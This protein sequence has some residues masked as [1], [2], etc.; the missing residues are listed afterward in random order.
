MLKPAKKKWYPKG[1]ALLTYIKVYNNVY[2]VLNLRRTI[3]THICEGKTSRKKTQIGEIKFW[4]HFFRE[5]FILQKFHTFR[6]VTVS[7]YPI[8][9]IWLVLTRAKARITDNG[10][11]GS[12]SST[13]AKE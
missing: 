4:E 6:Y 1:Q 12:N 10:D 3:H 8:S 13:L 7:D 5:N 2:F 9:L 11:Y